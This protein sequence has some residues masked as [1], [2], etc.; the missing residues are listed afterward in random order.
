MHSAGKLKIV[1]LAAGCSS[2][3]G[4]PKQLLTIQGERMLDRAV[5]AALGCGLGTPVLVLG[6]HHDRILQETR[7]AGNCEVVVNEAFG[8]GQSTSMIAGTRR[9][10]D[11]C[12]G[13]VF[14]LC[15][16]PF[17]TPTLVKE[18][19][20]AFGRRQPDLLYPVYKGQ[21]GNP[22]LVHSRL[23]PRLLAATGD[24]GARFLF[25]DPE[26]DIAAHEVADRS[27]IVDIDTPE[28]YEAAL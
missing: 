22:V 10:M 21:R 20:E 2:R 25:D 7:L 14:L 13:A 1:I 8:Q 4:S 11:R 19:A 18:L 26:L 12:G 23:F 27:V 6:A 16:Q 28:E 9:I 24:S 15:D 5:A 3:M 17:I